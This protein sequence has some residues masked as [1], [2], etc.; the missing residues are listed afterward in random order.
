MTALVRAGASRPA[1]KPV[2]VISPEV[3]AI[4]GEGAVSVE[5]FVETF[6]VIIEATGGTKQLRELILALGIRGLLTG[7][8]PGDDDVASLLNDIESARSRLSKSKVPA[9][10]DDAE[11]PPFVIPERW[12]WVRLGELGVFLGGGTP[13]KSNLAFWKGPIPWVS[14]KDM[15]RPYIEDA[16]DHISKEAVDGSTAKLIPMRSLLFVVRGMILAHSF[17]TAVTTSE[18]TINQDMKAL[19]LG[20]PNLADFLLRVC[21][22]ARRRVL[23]R[24]ERSTHGT[25]RLDSAVVESLLVPLPPLAEQKRI[26]ARV[27][28]LMALIDELE[29]KQNRKR[30]IGARFTKASLEAL[31]TAE[32]PEEFDAAWKRV[33]ENWVPCF[34]PAEAISELRATCLW[35]CLSG[36]VGT[37]E[38]ERRSWDET[39]LG[40]LTSLVTSGSR[41]W[42]EY[43]SNSGAIF[44]R[45]QDIKT[46]AVD[47]TAPSY[48]DLPKRVEGSRTRVQ[49]ADVLVTITGA[50]VGKAAL[51]DFDISEAYVSQHVALIRLHDPRQA[52]WV[53]RW[54]VSPQNGRK[55]LTGFSYGDKPGLNLDNIKSVPILVPPL[56]QQQR[57]V[58]KIDHLMRLCDDLEAKLR[59]AEDRASKL[60]EAIVGEMVSSKTSGELYEQGR[61]GKRAD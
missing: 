12:R 54:L 57:I 60:A 22:D 6:P 34:A 49:R 9:H 5:R 20:L 33:V 43:Y 40:E 42:K 53:H 56:D 45:S 8:L 17:P 14:P 46:D 27:D 16:E 15:K 18:V 35:L 4:V 30:E 37:S 50:N 48:V 24:V 32:G 51:V 52:S 29:A 61:R 21:R 47:L 23:Q 3:E 58:A 1:S 13:S 38:A 31:T 55:T 10:D 7:R 59:R 36:K 19:V 11:T 26:V 2:S 25:C 44:I 39:T 28:Q 41:G